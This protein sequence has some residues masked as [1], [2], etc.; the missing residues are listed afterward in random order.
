VRRKRKK[1]VWITFGVVSIIVLV[2]FLFILFR[3]S[4]NLKTG[5]MSI[6]YTAAQNIQATIKGEYGIE[7]E[8][9]TRLKTADG[10]NT[11]QFNTGEHAPTETKS[12]EK[13]E[14]IK[15]E[16][17]NYF[18]A[19]YVV[20]NINEHNV[21]ICNLENDFKDTENIKIEYSKDKFNW[22]ESY[23]V[24]YGVNGIE[25]ESLKSVHLYIRISVDKDTEDAK[26][27]GYFNFILTVKE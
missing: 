20:K 25:I 18:I 21:I 11:L 10:T 13:V 2:V 14:N 26:F 1:Q 22:N 17:N 7:G 4:A 3:G 8:T 6:D 15:L 9:P 16:K 27:N 24:A 19:H 23:I 5:Q 12:F